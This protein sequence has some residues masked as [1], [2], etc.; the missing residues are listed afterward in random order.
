M[1]FENW[2]VV[3]LQVCQ[4]W[5]KVVISGE[6]VVTALAVTTRLVFETICFLIGL[7][8]FPPRSMS[9]LCGSMQK[10]N[11]LI[12]V[13]TSQLSGGKSIPLSSEINVSNLL[14]TLKLVFEKITFF[15]RLKSMP[16]T[17]RRKV[18]IYCHDTLHK[19]FV[20]LKIER[21]F[22]IS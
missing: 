17:F 5:R 2:K 14:L 6:I 7:N 21:G 20:Q 19:N 12:L 11:I 18:L 4:R 1:H 10:Y 16:T 15:N 13:S 8:R 9:N 3:Q 22:F